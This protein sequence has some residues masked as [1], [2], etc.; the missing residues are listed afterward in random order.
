MKYK[1]TLCTSVAFIETK[2]HMEQGLG[3]KGN[4]TPLLFCWPWTVEQS[5]MTGHIVVMVENLKYCWAKCHFQHQHSTTDLRLQEV[6]KKSYLYD[7][8]PVTI[9]ALLQIANPIAKYFY[10]YIWNLDDINFIL[11]THVFYVLKS[12]H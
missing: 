2:S 3:G 8:N 4:V 6:N 9:Y 7:L 5:I 1:Y 11:M 12:V 10:Y